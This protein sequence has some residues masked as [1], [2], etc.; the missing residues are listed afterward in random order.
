MTSVGLTGNYGMG[1]STVVEMFRQLGA[2]TADADEIVDTLLKDESVLEK[3]R[4]AF[5]NDVFLKDGRLDRAHIASIVF[6]DQAMRDILEGIIHPL[7]FERIER[8]LKETGMRGT[9]QVVV[10]EIPL[11]FEKGRIEGFHYTVAVHAAEEIVLQRLKA[12]GI[13]RDAAAVRLKAQMDI[14]EK[15]RLADFAIDN[16]GSLEETRAQVREI[17]GKLME[18]GYSGVKD[19]HHKRD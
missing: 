3:I 2:V 15:A 19:G 12:K 7:V 4:K 9:E 13:S 14:T 6:K 11:M 17:Y 1:K 18:H 10:V 16:S 8:F 5:G